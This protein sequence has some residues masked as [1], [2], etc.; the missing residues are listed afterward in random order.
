VTAAVTTVVINSKNKRYGKEIRPPDDM[1]L[2]EWYVRERPR[3]VGRT[4]LR[5]AFVGRERSYVS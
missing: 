4:T 2:D 3:V 5:Y 1:C